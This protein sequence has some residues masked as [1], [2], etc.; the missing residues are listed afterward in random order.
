M[1][2]MTKEFANTNLITHGGVFHA[3]EVVATVI[4]AKVL[5]NVNVCRTFKL[6]DEMNKSAIV[7]DIGFGK[8]DHHQKGGNG[9]RENGVPYASAGLIWRDFGSKLVANTCNPEEVWRFVDEELIQGIDAVDNGVVPKQDLKGM[10]FSKCVSNFNPGWDSQ[11][12]ADD[13][14][15]KA[16]SFAEIVFDNVLAN[17]ISKAKAKSGVEEAINHSENGIM[18]LKEFMP[19]QDHIFSS[20]NLKAESILFVVFPSNRGGYNVQAVPDAP[21]SMEKRKPLPEAWAGLNGQVLAEISGVKTATFCH[22]GRFI[23]SAETLE[24]ALK[25]ARKA[26]E[27]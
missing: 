25:M 2:K 8:Y 3:D 4:L 15:V 14:F 9:S 6:P 11:E 24:D 10:S 1:I 16:C 27:E 5:G 20:S 23:C 19:W 13:A 17:A 18:I 22:T 26:I 7:Y 12:A 21:G